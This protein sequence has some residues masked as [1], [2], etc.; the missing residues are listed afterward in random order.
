[1][2]SIKYFQ[3]AFLIVGFLTILE[4]ILVRG[5]FTWFIAVATTVLV[6]GLNI[7]INIKYREWLQACLYTLSTVALCMGYLVL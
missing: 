5:M 6:G 2:K 3:I 7:I 4:F 1:M